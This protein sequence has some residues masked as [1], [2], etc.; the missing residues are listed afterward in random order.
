MPPAVG[1]DAGASAEERV[2]LGSWRRLYGAVI[3]CAL[4][5]MVLAA[6][7]SAWPY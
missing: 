7:F 4:L 6:V 5:S 3:G 2:P 1:T